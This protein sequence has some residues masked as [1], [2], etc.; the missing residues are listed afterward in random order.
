MKLKRLTAILLALTLCFSLITPSAFAYRD[1]TLEQEL[2]TDLKSLSLF[3]G[4]SDT[5]FDL[6]RAPTRTEAVVMLIRV[7]GKEAEALNGSWS[8]PF[9]DVS[10][11]ADKY[12]GYA[13]EKGLAKGVSETQF[14]SGNATAAT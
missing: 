8:H 9:T 3:K 11:W 5:D 10:P 4:V 14:G 7:L 2:A 12:V 6:D 13:Y 1:I